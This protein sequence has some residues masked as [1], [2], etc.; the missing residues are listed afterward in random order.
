MTSD[1]LTIKKKT[2]RRRNRLRSNSG[3]RRRS[4][5]GVRRRSSGG[6][7]RR[8]SSGNRR[9]RSSGRRK[10]SQKTTKPFN[11]NFPFPGEWR[12][13]GQIKR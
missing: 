10:T 9:R 7:R 1:T 13:N 2:N 3:K 12:I 8:R 11:P 5:G 4:S 6:I